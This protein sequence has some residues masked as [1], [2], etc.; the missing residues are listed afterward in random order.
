[1]IAT[2]IAGDLGAFKR[3]RTVF[4]QRNAIQ[5][6]ARAYIGELV[7]AAFGKAI[8]DLDLVVGQYR[9]GEMC[10]IAKH[11]ETCC[12]ER[13]T[14]QDQGWV[15]RHRTEGIGGQSV[16]LA[17]GIDRGDHGDARNEDTQDIAQFARIKSWLAHLTALARRRATGLAMWAERVCRRALMPHRKL[18]TKAMMVALTSLGMVVA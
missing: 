10:G 3:C 17:A 8:R 16:G 14:P 12:I 6:R 18:L 13:L 5:A 15:E 11:R 9:Y 7:R 1:M 4:D 2:G